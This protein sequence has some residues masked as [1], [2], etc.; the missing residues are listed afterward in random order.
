M[1][2]KPSVVDI[3]LKAAAISLV[4]QIYRLSLQALFTLIYT[5]SSYSITP[6]QPHIKPTCGKQWFVDTLINHEHC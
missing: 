6:Y 1:P 3:A 2:G 4:V 5:I